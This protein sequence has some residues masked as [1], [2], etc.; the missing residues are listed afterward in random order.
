[1]RYFPLL[2]K[3]RIRVFGRMLGLHQHQITAA[4][5]AIDTPQE[6]HEVCCIARAAGLSIPNEF[7]E[8]V[9]EGKIADWIKKVVEW[10]QSEEG[11]KFLKFLFSLLGFIV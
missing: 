4:I 3:L 9:K 8:V 10:L 5:E 7:T 6:F 2:L 1:M 11:K